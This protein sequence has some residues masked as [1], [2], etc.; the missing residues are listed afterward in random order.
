MSPTRECQRF[1]GEALSDHR[2][3]RRALSP[4]TAGPAVKPP[5][6]PQLPKKEDP[7]PSFFSSPQPP[8]Q[9]DCSLPR[10]GGSMS[11]AGPSYPVTPELNPVLGRIDPRED[12]CLLFTCYREGRCLFDLH[13]RDGQCLHRLPT[14]DG[15]CPPSAVT[16][17]LEDE[18]WLPC[19]LQSPRWSMTLLQPLRFA[20][21]LLQQPQKSPC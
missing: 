11:M 4:P 14:R 7:P 20:P 5:S 17:S 13:T 21:H 12:R 10:A 8:S 3:L 2:L 19:L 1:S 16:A 9:E 6:S 15:R 18:K